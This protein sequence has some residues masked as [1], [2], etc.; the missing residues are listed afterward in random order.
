MGLEIEVLSGSH[1]RAAFD[2]GN[3]ELNN[4][5]KKIARQHIVKGISRTFVL[6][7]TDQ[8]AEIIAYMS[9]VACEVFTDNIPHVWKKKYPERIP[10][11]K[12]A[13]LAVSTH[14]QRKG[15]G[16]L[17]L[18]DAMKKTLKASESMGIAGLFVDAKHE[19]AKSYY[20]QF[21]FISLPEQLENL[22][23][24]LTTL[25]NEVSGVDSF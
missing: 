22:F 23:L 1:D 19:Q 7:D 10:A 24:P 11:A 18:V 21:G 5:L 12:L 4:F 3:T 15:F 16:E 20:S 8:P 13:R 17:L 9:M 14:Q 25:A 2:C 6:I